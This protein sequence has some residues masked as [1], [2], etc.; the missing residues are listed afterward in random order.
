[1]LRRFETM[2]QNRIADEAVRKKAIEAAHKSVH[3]FE[4]SLAEPPPLMSGVTIIE[5]K[6][7]LSGP[8]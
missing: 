7:R 8:N 5:P 6:P 1:M 2:M 3:E 4:N